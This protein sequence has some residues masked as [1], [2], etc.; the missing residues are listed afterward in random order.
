MRAPL[1]LALG[2]A[3]GLAGCAYSSA[4]VTDD[5]RVFAPTNPAAI[6]FH[7]GR[8]PGFRYVIIGRVASFTLGEAPAALRELALVAAGVG[9]DAV[10]DLKLQ[11]LSAN[12]GASGLAVKRAPEPARPVAAPPPLPAAPAAAPAPPPAPEEE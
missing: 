7:P 6:R 9:A 8:D 3:A 11:K 2:L 1:A 10:L 12:T 5:G 4:M